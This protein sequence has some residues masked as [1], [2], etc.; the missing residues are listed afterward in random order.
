MIKPFRNPPL[1]SFSLFL[2]PSQP[3]SNQ[4]MQFIRM[5]K[6]L[7]FGLQTGGGRSKPNHQ[8]SSVSFIQHDNDDDDDDDSLYFSDEDDLDSDFYFELDVEEE[9]VHRAV[10][11]DCHDMDDGIMTCPFCADWFCG[12]CESF[13]RCG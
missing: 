2:F 12:D 7:F 5:M 3:P 13:H 9:N 1:I 4:S 10:C 8:I 11:S 6:S